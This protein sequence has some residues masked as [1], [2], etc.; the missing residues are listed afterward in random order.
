MDSNQE[1]E[2][3]NLRGYQRLSYSKISKAMGISKP[4]LIKWGKS[5]KSELDQ[6]NDMRHRELLEQYRF[7]ERAKVEIY[8]K[9][10]QK[11]LAEIDTR[12][13]L[14]DIPTDKLLSML[15][16]TEKACPIPEALPEEHDWLKI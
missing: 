16:A 10:R 11:I 1:Q 13:S 15:A 12:S 7:T 14:K 6:A 3:I 4:T 5:L 8:G 9:V 2:F